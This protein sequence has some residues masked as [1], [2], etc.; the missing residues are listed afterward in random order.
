VIPCPEGAHRASQNGGGQDTIEM[1]HDYAQRRRVALALAITVIA[2]PAAFL[3]N[4]SGD[5]APVVTGPL[6]T[7][8]G[9]VPSAGGEQAAA[10]PVPESEDSALTT[11]A[12][13]TAPVGYLAGSTVPSDNSPAQIAIPRLPESVRGMATFSSAIESTLRCHAK[14]V[15]FNAT[16]TVT[17]LDNSRSVQCVASIGG[18]PPETDIVL[19]TDTFAEIADLTDAP[20]PVQITWVVE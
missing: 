4:R 20:V 3:L 12:L 7:L 2:A 14:G 1:D 11:T 18:A 9:T 17:N 6:P 10:G 15:P 13:G 16:L 8:V 19:A 5:E